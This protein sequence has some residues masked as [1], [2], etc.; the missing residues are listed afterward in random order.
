MYPDEP[1]LA[2]S[3]VV[4]APR[5]PS[6]RSASCHV[7]PGRTAAAAV[8]PATPVRSRRLSIGRS[9]YESVGFVTGGRRPGSLLLREGHGAPPRR[10]AAWGAWH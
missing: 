9:W 10:N 7:T 5:G 6:A 3:R 2:I 4:D 8:R 1:Q